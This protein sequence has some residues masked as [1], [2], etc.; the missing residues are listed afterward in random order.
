MKCDAFGQP[1]SHT[2]SLNALLERGGI[3]VFFLG[4]LQSSCRLSQILWNKE[5]IIIAYRISSKT[6]LL[7]LFWAEFL[8]LNC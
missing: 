3:V 4:G 2:H 1:R 5:E 6:L 7:L 8:L